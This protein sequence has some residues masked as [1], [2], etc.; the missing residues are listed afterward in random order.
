MNSCTKWDSVKEACWQ[1]QTFDSTIE[2]NFL[3][4]GRF[5]GFPSE[6]LTQLFAGAKT[7]IE[8]FSKQLEEFRSR[9]PNVDGWI[10]RNVDWIDDDLIP[11]PLSESAESVSRAI[12]PFLIR[13]TVL[14]ETI[15]EAKSQAAR[16]FVEGAYQ[17]SATFRSGLERED[18]Q[19]LLKSQGG[20][21]EELRQSLLNAR[22]ALAG[23]QEL[24]RELIGPA[25]VLAA[26]HL[27][28]AVLEFFD[29]ID[30]NMPIKL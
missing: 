16:T 30:L 28:E 13:T 6:E 14:S 15:A 12:S 19:Y 27:N 29:Q 8:Q 4:G 22:M 26:I 23:F 25:K 10:E 11:S 5:I 7:A 24:H 2:A 21:I 18:V 9:E 17:S 20:P 1:R 3:V